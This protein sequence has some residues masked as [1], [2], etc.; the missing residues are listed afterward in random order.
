ME[1]RE[2]CYKYFVSKHWKYIHVFSKEEYDFHSKLYTCTFR[3]YLPADKQAAIMDV[4]CGAGHFLYFLKKQG[5]QNI[6]GIDLSAEQL[7]VARK[8]GVVE[9]TEADLFKYLPEHPRQYDMIIANDIIE[10]LHKDEVLRLLDVMFIA[11]RPGG[12]VLI[13]TENAASLFGASRVF[14]DFTHEQGFTPISLNQILRVCGFE[15]VKVFGIGPIHNLSSLIRVG[16]WKIVDCLLKAFL[17]IE[18]GLGRGLKR[19]D[20]ILEPRMFAIAQK[21]GTQN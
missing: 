1:Y 3:K 12:K 4:A 11:L 2:R 18:C 20:I 15:E 19:R 16:L 7:A 5:Y 14:I 21:P 8:M 17:A 6:Q 9:V 13:S 10:H